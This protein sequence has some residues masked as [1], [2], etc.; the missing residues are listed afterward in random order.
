M[1]NNRDYYKVKALVTDLEKQLNW[2]PIEGIKEQRGRPKAEWHTIG[3][4]REIFS[5]IPVYSADNNRVRFVFG[6][7]FVPLT[8]LTSVKRTIGPYRFVTPSTDFI[9]ELLICKVDSGNLS[10][11]RRRFLVKDAEAIMGENEFLRFCDR[12]QKTL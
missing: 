4:D 11:Q 3:N 10:R 1:L 7:D 9:K 12:L 2:K 6:S 8:V 5:V